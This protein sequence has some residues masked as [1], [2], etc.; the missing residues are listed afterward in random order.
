MRKKRGFTG[1]GGGEKGEEI[2]MTVSGH[3]SAGE[4][5]LL[6]ELVKAQ[7]VYP[8]GGSFRH[9]RQYEKLAKE[10]GYHSN[11]VILPKSSQVLEFDHSGNYYL[12][13]TIKTRQIRINQNKV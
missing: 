5:Q 10:I 11:Q 4:I 13:E 1:N 12:R 9:M 2:C 6:M 7:Y 3:A 8:I